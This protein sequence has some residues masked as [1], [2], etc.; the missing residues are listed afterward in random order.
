[1]FCNLPFCEKLSENF[2]LIR[3]DVLYNHK[4]YLLNAAFL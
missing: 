1:M 3:V 4:K 2:H